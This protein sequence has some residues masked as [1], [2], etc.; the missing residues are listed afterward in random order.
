MNFKERMVNTMKE[1]EN[2]NPT[3][4]AGLII[5]C[6]FLS[7]LLFPGFVTG[8][9]RES[10]ASKKSSYRPTVVC[11]A[12]FSL[13]TEDGDKKSHGPLQVR[14]RLQNRL[15]LQMQE[16]PQE[17]ARK[18][19]DILAQSIVHELNEKN[20]KAVRY[21][22]QTSLPA[23]SWLLEGEFVEYDEGDRLKR[24]VIGFGSGSADMEIMMKV[25]EVVDSG[26]RLLFDSAMDGKK[27][28]MPGAV[29]TMNPYVAGAK[30]VMTKTAP[31]R[32]V[33]KLGIRIANTLYEVIEGSPVKTQH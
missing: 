7:S 22:E 9:E 13:H 19:V 29:V 14:N 31:E 5:I 26:L 24:T 15:D 20:I 23:N 4:M 21:S 18:I 8:E 3:Y 33:K 11:V 2:D 16:S 1:M 32:E 6:T 12:D 28:R 17:K 25:S 10:H 27:N 30:F